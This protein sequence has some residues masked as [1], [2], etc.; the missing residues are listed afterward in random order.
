M[1]MLKGKLYRTIVEFISDIY[2]ELRRHRCNSWKSVLPE[3]EFGKF[4]LDI[5]DENRYKT[6]VLNYAMHIISDHNTEVYITIYSSMCISLWKQYND[7]FRCV[8]H[9]D[10]NRKLSFDEIISNLINEINFLL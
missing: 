3:K 5:T 8:R 9:V 7:E 2:C 6:T 10:I 4:G 1:I